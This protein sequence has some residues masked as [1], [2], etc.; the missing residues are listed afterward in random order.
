M[1]VTQLTVEFG[2]TINIGNYENLKPSFKVVADVDITPEQLPASFDKI[3][4]QL[5]ISLS[6][7]IAAIRGK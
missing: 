4:E 1:R 2:A 3:S 5:R 7:E 6:E